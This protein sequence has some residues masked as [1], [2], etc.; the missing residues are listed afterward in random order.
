MQAAVDGTLTQD[1]PSV[2]AR[3]GQPTLVIRA[4]DAYGP[5]GSSPILPKE[6]ADQVINLLAD[7]HRAEAS[8][9]HMTILFGDRAA[10]LARLIIDFALG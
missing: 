7:P 5:P 3:G 6:K 9:N 10:T 8:G 1:W 4:T 2:A